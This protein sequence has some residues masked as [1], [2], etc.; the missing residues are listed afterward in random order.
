LFQSLPNCAEFQLDSHTGLTFNTYMVTNKFQ[1]EHAM[2][3]LTLTVAGVMA[4]ATLMLCS[5]SA[6]A[7][8]QVD[9]SVSIG[10]PAYAPPPVVYAAPPVVYEEPA[11]VVR[12]RPQPYYVYPAYGYRDPYWRRRAWREHEWREHER[13]EHE[14]RHGRR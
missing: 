13:R 1:T 3:K 5:T 7:H 10:V 11:P 4:G 6:M 8:G 9:W 2:K 12:Y 14:E